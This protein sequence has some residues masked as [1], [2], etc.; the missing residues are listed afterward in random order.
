LRW[1]RVESCT[2]GLVL[3]TPNAPNE[4]RAAATSSYETV[5]ASAPFGCLQPP[6][7]SNRCTR[8]RT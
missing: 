5:S 2:T 8:S 3:M 4:P 1:S 6:L 7:L